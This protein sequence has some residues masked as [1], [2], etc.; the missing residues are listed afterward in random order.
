MNEFLKGTSCYLAGN[1]EYEEEGKTKEWRRFFEE[2][3]K[4][5]GIRCFNPLKEVFNNFPTET[6]EERRLREALL[7]NGRHNDHMT[8][9][10]SMKAVIRR[11]LRM[12]D[13]SDFVVCVLN[14]KVPTFGTV[15]EIILCLRQSKPVL[16]AI[17]GGKGNIPL[18]LSGYIHPNWW[19]D[20]INQIIQRLTDLNSGEY[21]INNKYWKILI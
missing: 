7:K 6:Q 14:P 5:M 3:V 13:I 8:I 21:P 16:L 2:S 18:W 10:K 19:F 12:V 17:E 20:D 1:L 11:D 4:G 15:D 9:H